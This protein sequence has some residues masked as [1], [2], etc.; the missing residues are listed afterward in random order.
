MTPMQDTRA[1]AVVSNEG[2][3]ELASF[4][5]AENAWSD[6]LAYWPEYRRKGTREE[7]ER[8]GF[9]AREVVILSA[10]RYAELTKGERT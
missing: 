4:E 7:L 1:W 6:Y 2:V 3:A 5:G 8:E 9:T 10:E